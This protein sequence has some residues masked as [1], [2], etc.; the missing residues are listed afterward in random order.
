MR[1][2]ILI[3]VHA[4]AVDPQR[5]LFMLRFL[6][7]VVGVSLLLY[8]WRAQRIVNTG[9]FHFFFVLFKRPLMPVTYVL[10]FAPFILLVLW[11]RVSL[12]TMVYNRP[13]EV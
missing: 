2:G 8:A 6:I 7:V 9:N 3:S 4:F 1:S 11:R 13:K 12:M 5:G 10:W